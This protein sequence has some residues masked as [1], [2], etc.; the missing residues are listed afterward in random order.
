MKIRNIQ[1]A[2]LFFASLIWLAVPTRVLSSPHENSSIV[3]FYESGFPAADTSPPSRGD[4]EA[5]LP[6]ARFA[7]AEELPRLLGESSTRLLVL[8]YGSAYPEADWDAI[9]AHLSR[10]GNLLVLGGRPFSRAGYHDDSGWHLREYSVRAM[11]PLK[12]DQY[13][14]TPGSAGES[15]ETNPDVVTKLDAFHWTQAF[16]PV[17]HL[18]DS[19]VYPRQ[20][21][22]GRIDSRLDTL[23]WGVRDGRRMSVPA[24]QIDHVRDDFAG[25]RWV[26]L[27]ADLPP[28][29]YSNGQSKEI[30]P[31]LASTSLQGSEEFIA[32]PV[33]PLYLPGEP[34]EVAVRWIGEATPGTALKARITI[35]SD[36][37]PSETATQTVTIPAT[38]PVL[39]SAPASKG[40]HTISAELYEGDS[41]RAVYHSAFWIRDESYLRSGPRLSVDRNYFQL[42]GHPLAVAGTTYMS[43]GVQ[44]LYFDHPNVYVWN[45]DMAQIH[46][47]G[48]NMLRTGWWTGW[49]KI[50]DE[51]GRPYERALR[52]LE[53][54]LMTA[55][56]N[57]L[58]VQ[59]T[60]FAFLPDIL[61]G[62]NSYLD[63]QAVRRETNLISSVVA[64]FHDV[65]FVAWDLINEP[66]FSQHTWQMRPNGDSLELNAW[67]KWLSAR[68]PDR[69]ALADD[70][71]FPSI[72]PGETLPVPREEEFTPRGMYAGFNSLKLYDFY[73]FAQETFADWVKHFETAIRSTGSQ[74]LITVGQDE[75]GY[76]DRLSP[77]FFGPYV[78]F[79]AN[80]SWWVNDG[81]LW[82]SLVAKQP[83][84]PMLIQETGLQRELTLDEIARRTQ[85][86]EGSL[87]ERKVAM[88]FVEGSG[89]IEW[90]WN[91]NDYMTEGNEVPIGA[92]RADGTEKPVATVLRGFAKFSQQASGY[93]S[94]P[95]PPLVTIVTSQ[96]AQ[97]SAIQDLQVEAQRKAA[98]AICYGARVSASIL[99]ENEIA[100]LGSP[101]LV[102]LPSAQALADSTWQAL[103]NYVSTGGNLLVTG[104]VD[105]DPH[106]HR[107]ERAKGLRLNA[108][109][110][111]LTAHTAE[112]RVN[113]EAIPM[114]FDQQAQ[115]WLEEVR[116]PGDD[117]FTSI[118]YGKGHIYWAAYPVE[119]ANGTAPATKL[120]SAVLKLAG[121]EPEF[122][123]KTNVSPGVLIYPTVL[124]DSVLYVIE[125]ESDQDQ[126]IDLRDKATGGELKFSLASQHAAVAILRKSDGAIV[127][128]YGF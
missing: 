116:M 48:L 94:D 9:Y 31:A 128:R 20:G 111:A 45:R 115:S 77:A 5:L 50:C 114:S 78:S 21:S 49:D 28:D 26:F 6:G 33:L 60:F 52:T 17:L 68:Y 124:R 4:L 118:S 29:F 73:L 97:F 87:F 53:A 104:P 92:L 57:G 101:R 3:I 2:V 24:M 34:V 16:S 55:R 25:G 89:A 75:G 105:R 84:L 46:S 37:L 35:S 70:W 10:G 42:D 23:A 40:F 13:Q 58:P 106:W 27:S 108:P 38:N 44:R 86:A 62:Q 109:A 39:F 76:N 91:S 63:P 121:I 100:K 65:P 54:Y 119:L 69:A 32:A 64:R 112:V 61:G 95:Q 122:E 82:D 99:A 88:S 93:L 103:L 79:S 96:A 126:N 12:I 56:R 66:S 71:G 80:H 8:P 125:S 81:L 120:Y 22:A 127:A 14:E 36:D 110:V 123:L 117:G 113:G 51:E 7:N 67:N 90:L 43:S 47:A 41:L 30:V 98:R 15:F 85:P 72:S 18:A 107:V 83:G 11:I 74:Q 102:I 1:L 19:D 59:F